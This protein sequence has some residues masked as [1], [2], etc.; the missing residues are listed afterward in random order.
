[1]LS[2]VLVFLLAQLVYL[3]FLHEHTHVKSVLDVLSCKIK[4]LVSPLNIEVE[5]SIVSSHSY[6]LVV[7]TINMCF[8]GPKKSKSSRSWTPYCSRRK[9]SYSKLHLE[10]LSHRQRFPWRTRSSPP[11]SC[12]KL[13]TK[14]RRPVKLTLQSVLFSVCALDW[15]KRST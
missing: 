12:V 14:I 13:P 10:S 2:F 8:I 4:L 3:F 11:F 6:P 7:L 9:L 5:Y 1:M 15:G